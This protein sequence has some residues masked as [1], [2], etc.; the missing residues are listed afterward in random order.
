MSDIEGGDDLEFLRAFE[1]ELYN[2]TLSVG[3]DNS[4]DSELEAELYQNVHF[5]SS[6]VET[7]ANNNKEEQNSDDLSSSTSSSSETNEHDSIDAER[8][9]KTD[10]VDGKS[11][12]GDKKSSPS[13]PDDEK[14]S[15]INVYPEVELVF[16]N[17]EEKKQSNKVKKGTTTELCEAKKNTNVFVDNSSSDEWGIIAADLVPAPKA[18]RKSFR[19]FNCNERGHRTLECPQPKK[20]KVCWLCGEIGHLRKNCRN[21]LCYNCSEQGHQAKKCPK[22]RCRAD[23]MCNR[24]HAFGHFE[25][26]CPDRWRQYHHTIKEGKIVQGTQNHSK[27]ENI[28]CYNCGEKGHL[29]HECL[30]QTQGYSDPCFPFV[31]RYDRFASSFVPRVSSKDAPNGRNTKALRN[32]RRELKRSVLN[33]TAKQLSNSQQVEQNIVHPRRKVSKSK[34]RRDMKKR[35]AEKALEEFE[36]ERKRMRFEYGKDVQ[37]DE[38]IAKDQ[39][40]KLGQVKDHKW[41]DSEVNHDQMETFTNFTNAMP[42]LPLNLPLSFDFY[43]MINQ[44]RRKRKRKNSQEQIQL[45]NEITEADVKKKKTKP[46]SKQRRA[47]RNKLNKLSQNVMPLVIPAMP[48]ENGDVK[49]KKNKKK[50]KRKES[51]INLEALSSTA[52]FN[53]VQNLTSRSNKERSAQHDTRN[54]IMKEQPIMSKNKFRNFEDKR[55][56]YLKT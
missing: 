6:L 32:L 35:M 54:F 40:E 53:T 31:A 11:T 21:E 36:N 51:K 34:R 12:H 23:D 16:S 49:K 44:N 38:V 4:L 18:K 19:C 24:C 37:S 56:V 22:P 47:M 41:N 48:A 55:N 52:D 43:P 33:D 9:P 20:E 14:D 13:D 7:P 2:D 17:D 39:S 15:S 42:N 5:A 10:C 28:F 30:E 29:G 46:G 25:S 27:R 26:F 50:K 3:S 8:Q 1:D 45:Q